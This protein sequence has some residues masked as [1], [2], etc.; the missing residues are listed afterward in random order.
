QVRHRYSDGQAAYTGIEYA[1]GG[2]S[3]GCKLQETLKGLNFLSCT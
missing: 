2:I 3:H 1:Y